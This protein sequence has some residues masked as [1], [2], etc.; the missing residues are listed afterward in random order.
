[1]NLQVAR[2][3]SKAVLRGL[4]YGE[5][6]LNLGPVETE[7]QTVQR[8]VRGALDCGVIGLPVPGWRVRARG[9]RSVSD[10]ST[11][12]VESRSSRADVAKWRSPVCCQHMHA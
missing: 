11:S 1:M 9:T 12:S 2:A 10:Y 4:D 8:I 5:V 6:V 7:G 3:A